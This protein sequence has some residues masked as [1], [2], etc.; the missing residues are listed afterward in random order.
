MTADVELV[1]PSG[2]FARVRP[3][4]VRDLIVAFDDNSLA[5]QAKLVALTTT[6][7]GQPLH[8]EQWVEMELDEFYPIMTHIGDVLRQTLKHTKGIA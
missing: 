1:L 5:M 8:L 4:T 6:I 7:D 3:I 2:R